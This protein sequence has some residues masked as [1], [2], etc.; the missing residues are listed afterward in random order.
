MQ[1]ERIGEAISAGQDE[2][3]LAMPRVCSVCSKRYALVP[4]DSNTAAIRCSC[5]GELV[6]AALA[7]GLY[8]IGSG[9]PKKKR[10]K[11]VHHAA[12]AGPTPRE[13]DQGYNESHGYGPSHGGPTS[14]GDAP[15]ADEPVAPQKIKPSKTSENS[16]NSE[17]SEP[18]P[19]G[20]GSPA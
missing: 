12:T 5:G 8:E 16:E 6:A 14:P 20:P 2:Q 9:T 7:P 13:A 19:D 10:R 3:A 1:Q 18:E 11:K 15:A 4:G 17:K